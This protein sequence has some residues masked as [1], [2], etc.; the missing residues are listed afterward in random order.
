MLRER[1]AS[2]D[3]LGRAVAAIMQAGGLVPDEMVNRL[4][5]ERI[6][7]PDCANGFILDGY[8]RTVEQ[9]KLLAECWCCGDPDDGGAFESRL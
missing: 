6:E 2:G 5:E 3:E 9:A 8:P 4:V 7:Q 1:V